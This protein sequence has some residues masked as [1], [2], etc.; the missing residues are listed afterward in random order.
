MQEDQEI[1]ER[2][3][4]EAWQAHTE[5]MEHDADGHCDIIRR[6]GMLRNGQGRIAGTG[7]SSDDAGHGI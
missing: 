5:G 6:G 1:H 4:G 2:R 7:G 3:N